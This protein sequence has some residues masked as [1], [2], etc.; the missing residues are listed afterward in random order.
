M[1]EFILERIEELKKS[2]ANTEEVSL[3][4]KTHKEELYYLQLNLVAF[5]TQDVKKHVAKL[6]GSV[7]AVEPS[8]DYL[9]GFYD[10]ART[11]L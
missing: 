6:S 11:R 9:K 2:V 8:Y 10:G 3:I 5:D 1:R 4:N 7:R